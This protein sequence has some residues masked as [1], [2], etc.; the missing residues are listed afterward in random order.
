MS[1]WLKKKKKKKRENQKKKKKER[2]KGKRHFRRQTPC[3]CLLSTN[4]GQTMNTRFFYPPFH[5]FVCLFVRI[6]TVVCYLYGVIYSE[7]SCS[8]LHCSVRKASLLFLSFFSL[9]FFSLFF[10]YHFL[11]VVIKLEWK[12][13]ERKSHHTKSTTAA[14]S[15]YST[16]WEK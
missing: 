10:F 2:K 5:R 16:G 4:S 1:C 9:F 15:M 3:R 8:V 7:H 14:R 6:M 11:N 12:K 13:R